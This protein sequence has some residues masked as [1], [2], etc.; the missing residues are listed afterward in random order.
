L[1]DDDLIDVSIY[2]EVCVVGDKN[3]LAALP[4]FPEERNQFEEH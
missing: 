3:D 4:S 1:S 2:D